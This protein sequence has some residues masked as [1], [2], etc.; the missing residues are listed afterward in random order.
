[1]ASPLTHQEESVSGLRISAGP[2]VASPGPGQ[3][4]FLSLP[5]SL[6]PD[7]ALVPPDPMAASAS[8]APNEGGLRAIL[9]ALHDDALLRQILQANAALRDEHPAL[10]PG[11]DD[12]GARVAPLGFEP[13]DP[14]E[15]R[16]ASSEIK[17]ASA[18]TQ[19][20]LPAAATV[21]IGADRMVDPTAEGNSLRDEVR[22]LMKVQ[23]KDTR[24]RARSITEATDD[25]D[26]FAGFSLGD[27]LLDSRLLGEALSSVVQRT[28]S[29]A[30]DT[31]FSVFGQ[32]QFELDLATD[33]RAMTV[34]ELTT[35]ASFT[36]PT[37]D[38]QLPAVAR[39]PHVKIDVLQLA[40]DFLTTP[41]GTLLM[42]TA[43]MLF[44]VLGMARC[45]AMMRR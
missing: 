37:P 33:T 30:G 14:A 29:I 21:V 20:A 6:P 34:S 35:G 18:A 27:R 2:T 26:D 22:A 4:V 3:P 40:W 24:A 32:G 31:T 13:L 36:L 5:Q 42:I 45:A 11:D 43:G 41:A 25:V 15:A 39:Q 12:E 9:E 8:R 16:A 19:Q 10:G 38:D 1:M 44:L 23:R 28:R 7:A 17:V